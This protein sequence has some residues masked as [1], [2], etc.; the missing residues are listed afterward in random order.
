MFSFFPEMHPKQQRWTQDVR[1]SGA[2]NMK[3]DT[4]A[5]VMLMFILT[6]SV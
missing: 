2:E 6:I 1:G 4:S 3:K 5:K